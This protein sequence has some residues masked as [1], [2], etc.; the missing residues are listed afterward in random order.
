MTPEDTIAYY[1]NLLITQYRILPKAVATIALMANEAY[2]QGLPFTLARCFDLNNAIGAQLTILGSIVGVPRYV[3][4]LD[5][6]HTFFSFVR[7]NDTTS[8]PGFGRYNSNPYPSSIWLRYISNSTLQMTD[9]E[10]LAAIQL[11]IIQNNQY[12]NLKDVSEALWSVFGNNIIVVDH[13]NMSIT[14]YATS[15]YYP[16]LEIALYL[17]ILPRAMGTGVSIGYP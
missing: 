7:Y 11:K 12:T 13:A 9:F 2:G 16:V 4:G 14:Y 6:N 10:M 15:N 17:G 1:T 5:L 8:R 3:Y